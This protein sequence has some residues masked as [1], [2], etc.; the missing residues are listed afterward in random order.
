M[1]RVTCPNCEFVN[2]EGRETCVRCNHALPKVKINAVPPKAQAPGSRPAP[3]LTFRPGQMVASRYSVVGVIGRGGMGCIYRV[4]DNVLKEE[5]ALKTLLP[6][7][8]RD[9]MVVERFFN[10]A[11]IARSLSHPNV[12]RVHDIGMT[13]NIIY[14]SMELV[15]GKTLRT[16]LEE[17][18]TGQ[19]LPVDQTL[20]IIDE[21]CAA[22]EY[23]HRYTIHRDIKP[24]NVMVGEDGTVKLMDFGISKLKDT[25]GLTAT[26]IVMGTPFYMSPEQLRNSANVDARADIYSLGVMLYEILTGNVPTG[27]PKPASQLQREVPPALDPIVSKCV[28]P[29]P[30]DRFQTAAELRAA[31]QPIHRLIESEP[32]AGRPVVSR[33]RAFLR[34]PGFRRA[35]GI[36]AMALILILAAAGLYAVD[37]ARRVQVA[38]GHAQASPDGGAMGAPSPGFEQQ[39]KELGDRRLTLRSQAATR[40]GNRDDLLAVLNDGDTKWKRAE[41]EAAS[42]SPAA[43]TLARQALQYYRSLLYWQ[44][45]MVFVPPGEV[46]VD[47][48]NLSGT[49]TVDGFFIDVGELSNEQYLR[50]C[51]EQG[52]RLPPYDIQNAPPDKPVV[53]VTFYDAQAFAAWAK[54][55]LPTE[56]QWARAAYG[57]DAA[58]QNVS[59]DNDVTWSGCRDLI[60]GISEWT[61]S[62]FKELPY[63]PSDG[64]EDPAKLYFGT[65]IVVRGDNYQALS[66]SPLTARYAVPFETMSET[67]GFR[68]VYEL[69]PD[70]EEIHDRP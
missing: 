20:G 53:D 59:L 28:E 55:K 48:G 23:A 70:S 12:I 58:T 33:R 38:K 16:I 60:G 3:E 62:A 2:P 31:L 17:L 52:W 68:C 7:F 30:K 44:P 6:Q 47:E 14:I 10:E 18:P 22:L 67:I 40:A 21:L 46:T 24:E 69:P 32:L 1:A 34:R 35:L 5:V 11:R 8:V 19:R 49:V 4:Q 61:R 66:P 41:T 63:G 27:V 51:A 29:N 65:L 9:K 25:T 26:S 54:K 39:F 36:A 37:R 13:G 15:K 43:L 50:F 42:Q 56:A 64:R 57:G 45:K